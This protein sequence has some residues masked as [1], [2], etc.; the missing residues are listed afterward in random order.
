[1]SHIGQLLL[2]SGAAQTASLLPWEAPRQEAYSGNDHELR[3]PSQNV[4]QICSSL[5]LDQAWAICRFNRQQHPS[6]GCSSN[7]VTQLDSAHT[8]STSVNARVEAAAVSH[9]HKLKGSS[10]AAL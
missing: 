9:Y 4:A 5:A 1:M 8:A 6:L 3:P 2:G 10:K 7:A